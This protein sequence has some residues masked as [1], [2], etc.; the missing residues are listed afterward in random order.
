MSEVVTLDYSQVCWR[1]V[2]L[3]SFIE[4]VGWVPLDMEYKEVAK[5]QGWCLVQMR[6][7]VYAYLTHPWVYGLLCS[8]AARGASVGRVYN[9]VLRGRYMRATPTPLEG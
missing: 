2:D 6:G 5:A 9:R 3:S 1:E 8:A 4:R 7:E